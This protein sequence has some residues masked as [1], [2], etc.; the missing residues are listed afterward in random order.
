VGL[1]GHRLQ[2]LPGL[3]KAEGGEGR[4]KAVAIRHASAS[5]RRRPAISDDAVVVPEPLSEESVN[6]QKLV[7]EKADLSVEALDLSHPTSSD[8][9]VVFPDALSEASGN[10]QKL[11]AEKADLS[12]EVADLSAGVGVTDMV[13]AAPTTPGDL[14][15]DELR[16]AL[17][18]ALERFSARGDARI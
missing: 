9:V 14:K 5:Q 13:N 8:D 17:S 15:L 16:S 7:A 3:Q 2:A 11:V 10:S 1:A 18:K 4:S 6:N 12:V